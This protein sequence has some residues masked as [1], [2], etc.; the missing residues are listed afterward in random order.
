MLLYFDNS[1]GNRTIPFKNDT[2]KIEKL[3]LFGSVK[4]KSSHLFL[5]TCKQKQKGGEK[6]FLFS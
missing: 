4:Y 2:E 6:R 3:M 1:R 5:Y